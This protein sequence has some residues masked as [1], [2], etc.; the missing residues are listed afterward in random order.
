MLHA[1]NIAPRHPAEA[2]GKRLA[3]SEAA[4]RIRH[5]AGKRILAIGHWVCH[6]LPQS[7]RQTV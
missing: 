5:G 3:N 6:V 2:L 4:L 1:H 7:R